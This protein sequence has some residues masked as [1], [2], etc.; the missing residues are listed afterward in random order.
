[1]RAVRENMG[2]DGDEQTDRYCENRQAICART[3]QQHRSAAKKGDDAD[4]KQT[5]TEGHQRRKRTVGLTEIN[6]PERKS[7]EWPQAP[8][9]V[10]GHERHRT[11]D[12]GGES[13]RAVCSRAVCSWAVCSWAVCSRAV[14]SWAVCSRPDERQ[15]ER[16]DD[17]FDQCNDEAPR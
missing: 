17:H 3:N 11:A 7:A 5:T 16:G 12:D 15:H 6:S 8:Q 13:S 2:P 10:S 14:C 1:M 4:E 9:R